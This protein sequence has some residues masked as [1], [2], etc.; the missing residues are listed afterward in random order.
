MLFTLLTKFYYIGIIHLT[1]PI[2]I[3]IQGDYER[4]NGFANFLSLKRSA[5]P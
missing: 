1:V 2:A 4:L 3:I 5:V